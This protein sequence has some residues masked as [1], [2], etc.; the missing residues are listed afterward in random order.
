MLAVLRSLDER[1][2][3][4]SRQLLTTIQTW[5]RKLRDGQFP[6]LIWLTG[7]LDDAVSEA[8]LRFCPDLMMFRKSLYTLEGVVAEVGV[9]AEVF[10]QVLITQFLRNFVAE[11]P[12]RWFSLPDSREFATRLSNCDLAQTMLS[13]PSSIARFWVGQGMDWLEKRRNCVRITN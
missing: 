11:W 7:M 6:G 13:L 1:G 4:D 2:E 10:D 12:S 8:G 3:P 9:R 5:L